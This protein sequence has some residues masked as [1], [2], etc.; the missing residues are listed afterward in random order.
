MSEKAK[1]PMWV[2]GKKPKRNGPWLLASSV[3]DNVGLQEGLGLAG[4]SLVAQMVRNL[5]MIR[6]TQV[7]SLGQEDPLK[8]GM[9]THSGILASRIP[10]TEKPGGYSLRDHRVGHD[11]ATNTHTRGLASLS[12]QA[13]W[14]RPRIAS[15]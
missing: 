6:E 3:S 9:T 7:R 8:K 11:R 1:I 4:A 14:D 5:P 15:T 13:A 2:K 10:W 12:L